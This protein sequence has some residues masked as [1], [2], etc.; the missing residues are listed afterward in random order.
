MQLGV[1]MRIQPNIL[2]A[3]VNHAT[4]AAPRE[5]CGILMA[6][7]PRDPVDTALRA[8]N[9]AK[10]DLSQE[11]AIGHKA[12]LRAVRMECGGDGRIVGYYH[13]H[14]GGEAKPS[15]EDLKKAVGGTVYLII[16][17]RNLEPEV[18]AW[19]LEGRQFARVP[20]EIIDC[21]EHENTR[22]GTQYERRPAAV[23]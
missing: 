6:A 19:R 10:G 14:P 21:H 17:L 3:I 2:N 5:C 23:R 8:E 4:D 16:G 15:A 7:R 12:H 11:Y 13:S 9:T 20:L 18:A 1:R 22:E